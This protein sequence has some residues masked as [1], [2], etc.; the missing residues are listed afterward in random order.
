MSYLLNTLSNT[1]KAESWWRHVVWT[2]EMRSCRLFFR[3]CCNV[4]HPNCNLQSYYSILNAL[5][6]VRDACKKYCWIF[7]WFCLNVLA[8]QCTC[9]VHVLNMYQHTG[10]S[11]NSIITL[12]KI[13]RKIKSLLSWNSDETECSDRQS[14]IS[15]KPLTTALCSGTWVHVHVNVIVNHMFFAC[16]RSFHWNARRFGILCAIICEKCCYPPLI[17]LLRSLV[18]VFYVD[19]FLLECFMSQC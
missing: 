8:V 2:N 19:N 11:C 4:L 10:Q 6:C 14:K 17:R 12:V 15:R 13:S 16:L 1:V 3:N 9:T 18:A 5:V 7:S